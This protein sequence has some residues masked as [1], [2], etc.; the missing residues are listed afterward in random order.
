MKSTSSLNVA[1]SS[2]SYTQSS[3]TQ[4]VRSGAVTPYPANSVI[5]Y[6]MTFNGASITPSAA[7]AN[8]QRAGVLG[9]DYVLLLTLP[10]VPSGK[11][12]GSYSDTITLTITPGT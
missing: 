6:S 12:A 2:T 8:H 9:S 10:G 3:V 11:L 1:V 7:L 5:P 4:L